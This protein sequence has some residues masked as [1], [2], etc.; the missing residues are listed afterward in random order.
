MDRGSG[1]GLLL[2]LVIMIVVM[3][4]GG[5]GLRGF[6]DLT[7]AL[8]VVGCTVAAVL[9]QYPRWQIVKALRD[10]PGVF[11]ERPETPAGVMERLV[12]LVQKARREG[13]LALEEDVDTLPLPMLQRSVRQLVDGASAEELEAYMQLELDTLEDEA[14]RTIE[15]YEAMAGYFPAFGMIGTIVGLVKML[16]TMD[17]PRS[18]G[19][20]MGLALVTT[21]YGAT[22]AYL[23][24]A[25]IAG[26]LRNRCEE[27]L[28]LGR[29]ITRAVMAMSAGENP[30]V[31]KELLSVQVPAG[32]PAADLDEESAAHEAAM[33]AGL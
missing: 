15:I 10:L 12:E 2:G 9:L 22:M 18:L 11:G 20:A 5:N 26:R 23:V 8:L 25:P 32:S 14:Y 13:I 7:S 24:C 19:A 6:V 29:M 31:L 30:T 33:E 28:L 21:F 27:D 17:D 3:S 16:L 1:A 4:M